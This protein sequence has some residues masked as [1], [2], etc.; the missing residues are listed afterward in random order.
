MSREV[1][2]LLQE[3]N[4]KD[5]TT[6]IVLQCAPVISGLKFSNLLTIEANQLRDVEWMIEQTDISGYVLLQTK[7]KAYILLYEEQELQAYL[8]QPEVKHFLERFHYENTSLDTVLVEFQSRYAKYMKEKSDF[9]HEMGVLLGYP[10]EDVE[11]FVCN[12]GKNSLYTGYWKVYENIQ[13]KKKIFYK[14]ECV[15]ETM[16][17]LLASGLKLEEIFYIYNSDSKEIL[18]M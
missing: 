17:Q 10:I 14:Y 9:P 16:L 8:N 18:V 6:Q 4:I 11:G 15:K 3:M 1:F 13:E 5:V 12:N 2:K 7:N